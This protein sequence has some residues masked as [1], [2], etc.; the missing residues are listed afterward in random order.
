VEKGEIQRL[1]QSHK[2]CLSINI[3]AIK[4]PGAREG[5]TT[6]VTNCGAGAPSHLIYVIIIIV[7]SHLYLFR[8]A[9][10]SGK[11]TMAHEF[12]RSLGVPV[13]LLIQDTWR[14][15]IHTIGREG[16]H[17]GKHEHRLADENMFLLLKQYLK[18]GNYIVIVEGSFTW[19]TEELSHI[20]GKIMA[21]LAQEYGYEFSSIVLKSSLN[22]LLRRNASNTRMTKVP[23]D[24]VKKMSETVYRKID[25]QEHVVDS[26]GKTVKQTLRLIRAEL[27]LY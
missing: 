1:H 15:G 16:G 7:K 17:I 13:A 12:G 10:A 4:R 5:V 8:G 3:Q 23:T 26:T 25:P 9:P 21:E 2:S 6:T 27:G 24:A 18:N 20:N 22:S 14:W 11:T 19:D